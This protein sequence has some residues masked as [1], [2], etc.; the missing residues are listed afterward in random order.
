[1]LLAGALLAGCPKRTTPPTPEPAQPPVAE[2]SPPPLL[3]AP[4]P[5]SGAPRFEIG[6]IDAE[7]SPDGT[8][9]LVTSSVRNIGTRASRDVKVWVDGLDESGMRLARTEIL[10][11]PQEI[12]PGDAASFVAQLPGNPAIRTFHVE[13]VGR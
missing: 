1:V 4:L 8:A 3:E 11:A 9:W 2:A 10:P 12:Q 7:R 6:P 13:A 5:P